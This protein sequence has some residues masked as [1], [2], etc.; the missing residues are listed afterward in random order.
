MDFEDKIREIAPDGIWWN[1]DNCDKFIF[2]GK[3]LVEK[4]MT[5][6]EAVDF[7]SCLWTAVS[8]EYGN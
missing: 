7:L 2:A 8:D 3:K 1:D 5:E 6:D 4:G